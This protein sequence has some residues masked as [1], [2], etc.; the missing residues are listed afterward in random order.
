MTAKVLFSIDYSEI[1][2]NCFKVSKADINVHLDSEY[3]LYKQA[4]PNYFDNLYQAQQTALNSPYLANVHRLIAANKGTL[5]DP[6]IDVLMAVEKWILITKPME[7][8]KKAIQKMNTLTEMV[9]KLE[10]KQPQLK[11]YPYKPEKWYAL[12]HLI[13]IDKSKESKIDDFTKKEIIDLGNDKYGTKQGFYN[14]IKEININNIP[15]FVDCLSAKDKK[16][17]KETLID[18]SGNNN[19]VILWLNKH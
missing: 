11:R 13:L 1:V 7:G 15:V 12:L 10:K 18:I 17:W 8:I 9:E 14:S 16:K 5:S 19:S 2:N 3:S 4:N 6:R